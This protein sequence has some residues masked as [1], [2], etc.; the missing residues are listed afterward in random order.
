MKYAVNFTLVPS[1]ANQFIILDYGLIARNVGIY[2]TSIDQQ[3][4]KCEPGC[5]IFGIYP[6]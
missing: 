5:L 2:R 6:D 1:L 4:K 3:E